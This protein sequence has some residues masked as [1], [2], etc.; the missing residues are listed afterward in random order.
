MNSLY[1]T[2]KITQLC[3]CNRGSNRV[4]AHLASERRST[5]PEPM[6]ASWAVC[7]LILLCDSVWHW[8]WVLFYQIKWFNSFD[9]NLFYIQCETLVCA[10]HFIN[11]KV[12]DCTSWTL[13]FLTWISVPYEIQNDSAKLFLFIAT[14][15]V[16][17]RHPHHR[18]CILWW[19]RCHLEWLGSVLVM[20][21]KSVIRFR[22]EIV[23]RQSTKANWLIYFY[24]QTFRTIL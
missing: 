8:Q 17:T 1:K 12:L 2:K 15:G 14:H 20:T 19:R 23:S 5:L 18:W 13:L 4:L 16:D 6:L 3:C 7:V 24:S 10:S 9:C 11:L 22:Q 21:V